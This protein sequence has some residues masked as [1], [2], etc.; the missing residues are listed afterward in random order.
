MRL[1]PERA[2]L[3]RD[4][5]RGLSRSHPLAIQPGTRKHR[6]IRFDKI[7]PSQVEDAVELLSRLE[8]MD[9]APGTM[10][11]S[12][13]IWYEVS[14]YTLEGIENALIS[15]GF[16]LENSLYCKLVR[17]VVYYCEATQ[18]RNMKVPER[19]IKKSHEVYSQ[20]WDHHAHGDHDDTPTDLREER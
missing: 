8:N 6:D 3:L 13:S 4:K 18:L 10:N 17:A 15:R 14:D 20:A 5:E 1:N 16:H 2:R 19:L 12:V 9:A 7:R 11:N